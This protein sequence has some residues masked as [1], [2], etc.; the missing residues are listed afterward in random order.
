[1]RTAV[2]VL[3]GCAPQAGP[4]NGGLACGWK[5]INNKEKIYF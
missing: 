3:Q 1:M 4:F 2:E 5:A